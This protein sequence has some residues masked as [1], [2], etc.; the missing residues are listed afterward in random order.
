MGRLRSWLKRLEH[1]SR[2]E[3]INIP[4]QDGSTTRFTPD[5]L[6]EAFL[7]NL[8]KLKNKEEEEHPLA[9]AASSSS[10]PRWRESYFSTP[11]ISAGGKL[12]DLSEE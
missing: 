1:T 2:R 11:A 4:Q 3:L 5:D 7:A 8:R 9:T 12:A 10:D 6:E